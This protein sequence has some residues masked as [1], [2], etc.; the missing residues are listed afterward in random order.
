MRFMAINEK[1]QAWMFERQHLTCWTFFFSLTTFSYSF[2]L[3]HIIHKIQFREI[4]LQPNER[5]RCWK[6]FIRNT[7]LTSFTYLN[8]YNLQSTTN[9]WY[10]GKMRKLLHLPTLCKEEICLLNTSDT[11]HRHMLTSCASSS[12]FFF[13]ISVAFN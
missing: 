10:S 5:K 2:H 13:H 6:M 1:F 7:K 11:T 12:S 4:R 3:D 8:R 9:M